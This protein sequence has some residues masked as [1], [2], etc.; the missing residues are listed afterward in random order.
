MHTVKSI[1]DSSIINLE[2]KG[3]S[4]PRLSAEEIISSVLGY[5]RLDLYLYFTKSIEINEI[6][7]ISKLI[8]R[9][10]TNEP[11]SYILK[12]NSFYGCDLCLTKDV[13]IPRPETEILVDLVVKDLK[14]ESCKDKVLWDLCCGSGCIGIAIKKALPEMRV[15]L[16]DFSK[17]AL[18]VAKKNAETNCVDVEIYHGDL[19]EAYQ[20][21]WDVLISN[22]PYISQ[23]E[24]SLLDKDLFFEPK[25]AL[26]SG[27]TG[28]EFYKRIAE[29]MTF[30]SKSKVFFEIGANQSKDV[31]NIF[32]DKLKK[33]GDILK[34]WSQK[35]RFF[36]LE[37]E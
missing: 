23:E 16:T 32:F 19:S 9:R 11:L 36:F 37:I 34:D 8:E 17:K 30:R 21:K 13:L 27:K 33:K 14:K 6:E 18:E 1:L 5:N 25:Q 29:D 2:E 15:I 10:S 7:Q 22:P 28:L 26:V 20:G 3:V 35:D 4:Y 24:Y 12:K 31:V